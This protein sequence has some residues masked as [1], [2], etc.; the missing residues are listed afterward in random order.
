MTA[1]PLDY[2]AMAAAVAGHIIACPACG[3]ARHPNRLQFT[4]YFRDGFPMC[5]GQTMILR[6]EV[7]DER[8]RRGA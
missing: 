6:R 7:H 8:V 5:C 1:R 4:A 3:E 2:G